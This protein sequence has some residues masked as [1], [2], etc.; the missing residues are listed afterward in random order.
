MTDTDKLNEIRDLLAAFDWE[1]DDRQ[2]ALEHIER[3]VSDDKTG[4]TACEMHLVIDCD[5]D[6]CQPG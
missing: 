5:A 3:I 6:E 1:R 2:Y 4:N